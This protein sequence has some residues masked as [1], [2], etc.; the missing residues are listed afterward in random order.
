MD[1]FQ[2]VMDLDV[3][4]SLKIVWLMRSL[5]RMIL[6]WD[7]LNVLMDIIM[8]LKIEFVFW[9]PFLNVIN[10][11]EPSINVLNVNLDFIWL[12]IN[13]NL[14]NNFPSVRYIIRLNPILVSLAIQ[15]ISSSLLFNLANKLMSFQD[16]KSMPV[17]QPVWNAKMVISSPLLQC[18]IKYPWKKIVFK[19]QEIIVLNVYLIMPFWLENVL[20][21]T[22]GYN[23]VV[24]LIIWM[25]KMIS[26]L[27][28]VILVKI[29]SSPW[30][31]KI[32]ISVMKRNNYTPNSIWIK[33]KVSTLTVYNIKLLTTYIHV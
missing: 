4:V 3:S 26:I 10:I 7:A 28:D 17:K 19:N 5:I 23:L 18:V 16:V 15:I 9:E 29:I 12:K 33:I 1:T 22:T 27:W 21:L 20:R 13:A 8:T 14:K 11:K 25:D 30:M 24:N 2:L 32:P 6:I 31:P